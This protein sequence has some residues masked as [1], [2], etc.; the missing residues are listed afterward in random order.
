MYHTYKLNNWK[1]KLSFIDNYKKTSEPNLEENSTS[2]PC[3]SLSR[4]KIS[5]NKLIKKKIMLL[6]GTR[7]IKYVS[8]AILLSHQFIVQKLQT[9]FIR[10]QYRDS[11]CEN[12]Y[13][14][15]DTDDDESQMTVV[16]SPAVYMYI[17]NGCL[18]LLRSYPYYAILLL[19]LVFIA[20]TLRTPYAVF[21]CEI[22]LPSVPSYTCC[23]C[24]T[25][26]CGSTD[27][28]RKKYRK[29]SV[30]L[31]GY[32][33]VDT[34]IVHVLEPT[35]PSILIKLV[36]YIYEKQNKINNVR[37]NKQFIM[38]VVIPN[39]LAQSLTNLG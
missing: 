26:Y 22:I 12:I 20:L 7:K 9:T 31:N 4:C 30:G 16:A 35:N 3:I 38:R 6:A 33:E 21:G 13:N 19:L 1:R 29:T 10:I 27:K 8:C 23:R 25:V 24:G 28:Y 36:K 14:N 34:D 18:L 17:V 37:K 11:H 5:N 15:T 2:T 39:I 32:I